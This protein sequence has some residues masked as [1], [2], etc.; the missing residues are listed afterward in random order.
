MFQRRSW[1][2]IGDCHKFSEP[3]A[4][5]KNWTGSGETKQMKRGNHWSHRKHLH[6]LV[7]H[8]HQ[9]HVHHQHQWKTPE[10][11]SLL[12]SRPSSCWGRART[13]RTATT[14]TRTSRRLS[15]MQRLRR[16]C[17]QKAGMHQPSAI[18]QWERL[19]VCTA[20]RSLTW[21]STPRQTHLYPGMPSSNRNSY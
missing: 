18:L 6:P 20:K 8:L 10:K 14:P 1:R 17:P 21:C 4:N 15:V 3:G 2:G 16:R 9:S 19:K 11:S 5:C 12:L 13:R 7:L